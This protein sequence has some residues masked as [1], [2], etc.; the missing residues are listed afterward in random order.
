[1]D[2][3]ARDCRPLAVVEDKG[4]RELN[5]FINAR[6][7]SITGD[8]ILRRMKKREKSLDGRLLSC[9]QAALVIACTS[10]VWTDEKM[11][12]YLSATAHFVDSQ[13]NLKTHLIGCRPLHGRHTGAALAES[14]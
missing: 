13:W 3:I 10:D 1:M 8:V 2:W 11:N 9:M 6:Y 14:F 5:S 12:T 7:R 4:F